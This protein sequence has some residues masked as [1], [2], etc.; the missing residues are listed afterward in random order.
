M[1]PEPS[2]RPPFSSP[3]RR[4]ARS[5]SVRPARGD[6]Y[7]VPVAGLL[8]FHS[9]ESPKEPRQDRCLRCPAR[10]WREFV[11]LHVHSEYS[12]LD[13]ACR[14]PELA[15]RAAELEMPAVALTD[16]GSLA[17][18]VELYREAGKHGRQAAARLRGLRRRRP[19]RAAEGLRASHAP[20]RVERGLCEPD[21][22]RLGRLP[23]GLLLQAARRLGAPRSATPTGSSRSQAA[24]PGASARRSRTATA[25]RPRPSSAASSTSSDADSVYVEI[26]DAGLDVQQGINAELAELA[27]RPGSRSSPPAT[28]TTSATRTRARTRRCSASSPGDTLANP[29]HWRFETDQFYFKTPGRDGGRTSPTT[30]RRSRRTLEIAERCTVTI[31]LGGSSCRRSRPRT[32]AT[33]STT[34]SSSARKACE[35][36]G[37]VTPELQERLKFELKTI[38]EMGFADYFLIVWDFIRSRSGTGSASGPGRGSAAGSLVAYCLEITDIDPIELRPA[39]RALPQPG[40]QVD[41]GHR[42]RLLRPRARPGHQ[43]RR[44]EVRARPRRADHHL[45]DDDGARR[46]A[47][48]RP[49]ARH[50]LRD[51]RQ[52]RQ[53][54]PRGPEGLPRRL[55]E[56]GR[57]AASRPTTPTRSSARSSTSRSRSRGS[58]G[59]TRSTPRAS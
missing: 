43:L 3:T 11:H 46:G 42:H 37:T 7:L 49:R 25:P 47:R 30:R 14:I 58:S 27:E 38:R 39:L 34:S 35:R 53:A 59:R 54:H 17:G 8:G 41:A 51:G 16:H 31:D 55:P 6:H 52:D 22:A 19:E 9:S 10:R 33:R 56:A 32:A 12:I 45:R 57:R 4:S 1:A 50:P 13:G 24:S 48:R 36:Y 23:R 2:R 26:Q 20:R 29:N 44:R 21:Q 40:P 5:G 15:E 28:S 18:A